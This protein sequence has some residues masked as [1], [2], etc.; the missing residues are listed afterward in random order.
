MYSGKKRRGMSE[1]KG[2]KK[3]GEQRES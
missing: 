3:R 2:K 1:R